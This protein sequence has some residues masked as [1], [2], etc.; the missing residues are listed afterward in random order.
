M[1]KAPKADLGTMAITK[2]AAANTAPFAAEAPVMPAPVAGPAKSLTIRLEGDLYAALRDYCYQRERA[3]G[4]RVT[5]QE[6]MVSAL[7][8]LLAQAGGS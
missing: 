4:S 6:V 8:G 5:H 7:K 2:A 3:T 1:A